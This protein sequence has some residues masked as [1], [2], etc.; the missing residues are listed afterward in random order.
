MSDP[1]VVVSGSARQVYGRLLGY[2]KPYWK[3]FTLSLVGMIVFAATEP[4]FAA[5]MQPLLDGSFVDKDINVVRAMPVLLVAL[6]VVRGIAGFVN[7]YF[8]S[9]VG[10]R[11]VADLRQEMSST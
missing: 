8:L 6:F 4:L 1:E 5:M 10:R 2:A 3:A 9:W 7:T 11:V